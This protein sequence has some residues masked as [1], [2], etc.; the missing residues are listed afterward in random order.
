[1]QRYFALSRQ[2]HQLFE[3]VV[4]SDEITNEVDLG[5]DDVDRGDVERAAI[6]DDKVGTGTA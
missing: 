6:A 3:V 4:G 1:M 2:G 5:R